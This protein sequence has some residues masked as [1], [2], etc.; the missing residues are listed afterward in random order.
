MG[1]NLV[2]AL[3]EKGHRVRVLV[4]KDTRAV[5][6][7]DVEKVRGDLFD[8]DS[9]MEVLSDI[10]LMYHLAARISIAGE[11][12]EDV[13]RVNVEGTRSVVEACLESRVG[14]LLHF[15]SIH[16]ICQYPKDEVIDETNPPADEGKCQVYDRT[17][18]L[19]ER[20]VREGI[21]RGLDAVIVN[22]TAILGPHDYKPSHMGQ[23]LL[24]LFT[25]R[26][27][28]LVEGGYN[29][30]DVRDV[31]RGAMSAAE[32]GRKGERYILSG[33]YLSLR[34]MGEATE[35]VS[36]TK[37]PFFVTPYR[38]ALVGAPFVTFYNKIR[39]KKPL[40]TVESLRNLQWNKNM[41]CEKSERELGYM[42]RPI[43]ETIADTYQWFKE[44]EKI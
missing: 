3:I 34:E 11:A 10:D 33:H 2:R 27:P 30:V 36:G 38:L 5:D 9:L 41:S 8:K 42:R 26:F 12:Y 1:G 20:V 37:M 6:G 43:R 17:K 25:G 19:G 4:R 18:A 13:H 29:W 16:A 14:R 35:E 31:V 7:L 32:K 28:A 40:Y 23:V 39:G 24:D 44:E 22:P 21:E 15:S